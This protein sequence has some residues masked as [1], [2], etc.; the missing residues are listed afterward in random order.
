MT[1]F[2]IMLTA[3]LALA[4]ALP[5]DAQI[6]EPTYEKVLVPVP[7]GITA[8]AFGSRWSASIAVSNLSETP[9]DVQGH[10]DCRIGVPCRPT[11][12]PPRTT[13][14]INQILRSNV[15]AAF[16]NVEPGR[17]DD[18]SI[19]MRVFDESR[20][21]LTWGAALPVITRGRLFAREFGLGD[22]P[23]SDA[24]RSTLRVFDFDATTPGAVRVLVYKVVP[25]RANEVSPGPP[26]ELLLALTPSFALPFEGGGTIG[27]PGYAS[28]PLWLLPELAGAEHVR[29]VIEPLD[30]TGDYW[31]MVSATHNETQHVTVIAP[32]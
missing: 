31:A 23:V 5:G 3:V 32:R 10:G 1:R 7:P 21:H 8:G 6:Y 9:V 17:V 15:P 16:L 29:I 19:T 20:E 30:E 13:I 22:I 18:L 2:P 26:D 24:F 11:P 14:Y 25:S 4:V 27:H 28:V 12:I